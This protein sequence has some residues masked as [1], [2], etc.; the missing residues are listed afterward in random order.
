MTS[1]F[2]AAPPAGLRHGFLPRDA[3]A[4]GGANCPA[5]PR[6]LPEFCT[7]ADPGC[8]LCLARGG[9]NGSCVAL[10]PPPP[11]PPASRAA[12][13]LAARSFG[14]LDGRAAAAGAGLVQGLVVRVHPTASA[15]LA[16]TLGVFLAAGLLGILGALIA[17]AL[18]V[19]L[20]VPP[21]L[22]G[23]RALAGLV[24]GT[25]VEGVAR[26]RTARRHTGRPP[27][28]TCHAHG[29]TYEE[30]VRAA[31]ATSVGDATAYV[32]MGDGA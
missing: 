6:T 31:L 23:A 29:G 18:R 11:L 32:A 4:R 14:R 19:P 27:C 15:P 17:A 16:A 25:V 10:P 21:A 3:A 22:G 9:R 30:E 1:G 13:P 20:R 12:C 26:A 8:D 2:A 7:A 28:A 24:A 5:S